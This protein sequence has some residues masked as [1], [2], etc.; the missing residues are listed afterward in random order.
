MKHTIVLYGVICLLKVNETCIYLLALQQGHQ[1]QYSRCGHGLTKIFH[2]LFEINRIVLKKAI[3][4][5]VS[6]EWPYQIPS[7]SDVA[8]EVDYNTHNLI[9]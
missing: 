6:N 3:N 9:D 4:T 7:L 2:V 8:A 5:T 1:K